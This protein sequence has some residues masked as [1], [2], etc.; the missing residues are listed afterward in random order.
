MARHGRLREDIHPVVG[1]VWGDRRTVLRI[2]PA[3]K[4]NVISSVRMGRDHRS[5]GNPGYEPKPCL[6]CRL[7]ESSMRFNNSGFT[8]GLS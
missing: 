8:G 1:M 6:G 5:C 3:F 2:S 4:Q 7:R